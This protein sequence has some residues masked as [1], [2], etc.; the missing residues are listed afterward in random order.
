MNMAGI[1]SVEEGR[2]TPTDVRFIY[3]GLFNICEHGK[4]MNIVCRQK[5]DILADM[6]ND[7]E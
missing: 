5:D 1:N 6:H 2:I 4:K 7:S 3:P